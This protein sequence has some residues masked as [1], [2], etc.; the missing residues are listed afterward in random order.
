[1]RLFL[2]VILL[3]LAT[4]FVLGGTARSA[5]AD[6]NPTPTPI[7]LSAA[8]LPIVPVFDPEMKLHLQSVL[9]DGAIK[10]NHR[11]IFAKIGDSM[12]ANPG[13]LV[14]IGCKQ[15]ILGDH[16]DLAA[17]IDYFRFAGFPQNWAKV[18]CGPSNAFNRDSVAAH[19]GWSSD[20][21]TEP[22]HSPV[23]GCP[24]PLYNTP[25]R[26]ELRLMHPA[27]AFILLGTNDLERYGNLDMYRASMSKLIQQTLDAGVIPILTTLPPRN[28]R[29]K[30]GA[31]VQLYNQVVIQ[32]GV[33]FQIPVMNLWRALKAPDLVNHGIGEDGVHPNL[34][35]PCSPVC[36][37][38]DFT[39]EGL[40]YGYNQF[41]LLVLDTLAKLKAII[42]DNGP[43]DSMAATPAATTSSP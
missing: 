43:A 8:D 13:Y 14:G 34:Y 40:R 11:N 19:E 3:A 18:A 26:C 23:P 37:G 42:I 35:G 22:L 33:Q 1:M 6:D 4:F 20:M 29:N 21:F 31:R 10:G 39:T 16:Q 25:L 38:V 41:N 28:D 17:V 32:I 12:S 2:A 30:Y 27:F 5:L 24:Q 36:S 15:E 7:A 9:T